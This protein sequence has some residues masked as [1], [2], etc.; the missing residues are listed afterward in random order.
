[1]GPLPPILTPHA[2]AADA[3]GTGPEA[4]YFTRRLL[5]S[6]LWLT[7]DLHFSSRLL[8]T[9]VPECRASKFWHSLFSSVQM[10]RNMSRMRRSVELLQ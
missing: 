2:H 5:R 9:G 6:L 7:R 1:M 4:T 10:S 3:S 8:V